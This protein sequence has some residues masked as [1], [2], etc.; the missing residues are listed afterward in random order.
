MPDIRTIMN[1]QLVFLVLSPQVL[2]LHSSM[3][4]SAVLMLIMVSFKLYNIRIII[5]SQYWRM[6]IV[7]VL[8]LYIELYLLQIQHYC[9]FNIVFYFLDFVTS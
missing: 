8:F 7:L 6:R 2:T 3:L 4:S 9:N 1:N 5:R